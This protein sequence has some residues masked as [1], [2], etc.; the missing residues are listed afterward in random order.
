MNREEGYYWVQFKLSLSKEWVIAHWYIGIWF[1][2]EKE[3]SDE[4][5]YKIDERRIVREELI[6]MK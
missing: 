5:M 6:K 3:F 4:D 2:G 1:W